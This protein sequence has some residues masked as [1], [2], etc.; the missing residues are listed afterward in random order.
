MEMVRRKTMLL[1][2]KQRRRNERSVTTPGAG[3]N[4]INDNFVIM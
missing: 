3:H 2:R 1:T 4:L